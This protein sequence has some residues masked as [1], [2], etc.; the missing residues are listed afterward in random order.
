MLVEGLR[1]LD[2]DV[3]AIDVIADDPA[4]LQQRLRLYADRGIRLCLCN[5]GTGLG[6]RDHTPEALHAVADREVPG[7]GEMFR[8]LSAAHTSLAWLSRACAV[9]VGGLLAIALPG[10][11]RAVA[12]GWDIVHPLLAH[13]LAMIDGS[14][15]P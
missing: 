5:G 8:Q 10:H 15:H 4:L 7:I 2:A 11:P 13:A 1:A 14:T 12:Q 6:P 9:Q 3:R